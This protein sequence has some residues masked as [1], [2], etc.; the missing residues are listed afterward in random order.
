MTEFAASVTTST[1]YSRHVAL[2]VEGDVLSVLY[3]RIGDAPERI[4]L[5]TARLRGPWTSWRLRDD[6]VEIL[7]P[8]LDWEGADLPAIPTKA[9]SA[10]EPGNELRDPAIL[11]HRGRRFLYYAFRGERGIGLAEITRR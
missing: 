2:V 5:A 8:E 9:G 11:D 10:E 3:S 6:A 7:R 4:M 1:E